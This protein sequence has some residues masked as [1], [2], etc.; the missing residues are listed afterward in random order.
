MTDFSMNLWKK[1]ERKKGSAT[2]AVAVF[3]V[4]A[5]LASS[6]AYASSTAAVTEELMKAVKPVFD[7]FFGQMMEGITGTLNKS[8][9]EVSVAYGKS[10]D[11][12]IEVRKLI[13]NNELRDQT[14]VTKDYCVDEEASQK[15]KS[16]SVVQKK[17]FEELQ[18]AS[19]SD[20]VG[21]GGGWFKKND[22]A[23]QRVRQRVIT[24]NGESAS[25][26]FSKVTN[27]N[28]L[29]NAN[30][31]K[32]SQPGVNAKDFT[33]ETAVADAKGMV[34]TLFLPIKTEQEKQIKDQLENG[35]VRAKVRTQK[36]LGENSRRNNFQSVFYKQIADRTS[37]EQGESVYSGFEKR[38]D[39][40]YYN[41]EYFSDL[42]SQNAPTPVYGA[43][44]RETTFG[45]AIAMKRHELNIQRNAMLYSLLADEMSGVSVRSASQYNAIINKN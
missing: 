22:D 12:A 37:N 21:E 41:P 11:A 40:T 5:T 43:V 39:E 3:A 20:G 35:D 45:N 42:S 1:P 33:S 19:A 28:K 2:P 15:L 31:D 17:T 30:A 13:H 25:V 44:L 24:N 38:L 32:P 26:D 34:D 23:Y 16:A 10:V 27:F 9:T 7:K 36:I 29:K 6:K 4:G 8:E 18:Q 14:R